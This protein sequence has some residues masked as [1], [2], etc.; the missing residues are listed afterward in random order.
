M[1]A[2]T[3]DAALSNP[4][5]RKIIVCLGTHA[6]TVSDLCA[7]CTLS[8]SAVSQHLMKLRAAGA[9]TSTVR[10]RERLYRVADR[11][12]VSICRTIA[13]LTT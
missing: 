4:V 1:D 8:Q 11:R 7:V 13:N 12:L 5:R 9:V 2:Q 6:K 3:I 10:G